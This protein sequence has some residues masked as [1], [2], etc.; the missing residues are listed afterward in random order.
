MRLP[1]SNQGPL[2]RSTTRIEEV[3]IMVEIDPGTTPQWMA[4][5]TPI[6]DLPS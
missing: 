3:A 4:R 1:Y 5:L 6:P 2:P